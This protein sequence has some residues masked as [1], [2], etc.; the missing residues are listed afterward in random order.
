MRPFLFALIGLTAVV[1]TRDLIVFSELII[2]RGVGTGQVALIAFYE[3]VP[4]TAQIF[5]FAVLIGSMVALGRFG[6]DRE[7]LALE[8]LG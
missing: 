1:L 6:A 8:S 4:M 7:I 3:A 2:N 5:P